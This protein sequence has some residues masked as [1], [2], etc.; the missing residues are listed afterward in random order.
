MFDFFPGQCEILESLLRKQ[1]G[2]LLQDNRSQE[3]DEEVYEP[4]YPTIQVPPGQR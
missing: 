2:I 4:V 1:I 3:S